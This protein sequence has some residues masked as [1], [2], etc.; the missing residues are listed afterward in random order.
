MKCDPVHAI[1]LR[2]DYRGVTE[3]YHLNKKHWITVTANAGLPDD[4]I[5]DLIRDSYN[6]VA[7]TRRTRQKA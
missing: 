3:G 5:R 6:L 1:D 2:H 7:P 4:L